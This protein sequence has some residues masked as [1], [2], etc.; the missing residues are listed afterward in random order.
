M[1]NHHHPLLWRMGDQ[2]Q[3]V[4]EGEGQVVRASGGELGRRRV[5]R[6]PTFGEHDGTGLGLDVLLLREEE[7]IWGG[8]VEGEEEEEEEEEEVQSQNHILAKVL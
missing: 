4:G 8:G 1:L 5:D 2:Q 7:D 3:D 6:E